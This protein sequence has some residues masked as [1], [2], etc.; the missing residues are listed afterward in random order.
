MPLL[1][2]H[3]SVAIHYTAN[4]MVKEKVCRVISNKNIQ[5]VFNMETKSTLKKIITKLKPFKCVNRN[6]SFIR[7]IV[8]V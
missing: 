3:N 5:I 1:K 8:L 2:S 4:K 6:K 7:F